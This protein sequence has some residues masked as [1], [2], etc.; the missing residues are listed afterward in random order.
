M[1]NAI[2]FTYFK[3]SYQTVVGSGFTGATLGNPLLIQ[4][5]IPLFEGGPG[6]AQASCIPAVDGMW[7]GQFAMA[8]TLPVTD[9]T[10][11]GLVWMG[12]GTPY[13]LWSSS[14]VYSGIPAGP[15]QFTVQ[16]WASQINIVL[17]GQSASSIA[18]ITVLELQ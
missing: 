3:N 5:T 18:S 17:P 11:E 14:R 15:H 1:P 6:Q 7:A 13:L 10:K 2:A 16:C 8:P 12:T 9:A 4:L